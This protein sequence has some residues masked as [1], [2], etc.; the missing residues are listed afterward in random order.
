MSLQETSWNPGR[1]E[2]WLSLMNKVWEQER[3]EESLEPVLSNIVYTS[4]MWPFKIKIKLI[5][6]K[7]SVH[8]ISC[9]TN[10]QKAYAATRLGTAD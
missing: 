6:I 1:E 5:K 4:H 2:M 9:F 8:G 7:K 10:A 3:L